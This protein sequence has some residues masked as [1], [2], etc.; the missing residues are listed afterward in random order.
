MDPK[1]VKSSQA[2]RGMLGDQLTCS[3]GDESDSLAHEREKPG[4]GGGL[5]LGMSASTSGEMASHCL[6]WCTHLTK[7]SYTNW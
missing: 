7:G 1:E 4:G 2:P 6:Q 5:H 3:G